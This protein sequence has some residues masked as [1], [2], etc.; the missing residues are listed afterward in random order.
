MRY[1]EAKCTEYITA[2]IEQI[3]NHLTLTAYKSIVRSTENPFIYTL[4]T[5][6]DTIES[7]DI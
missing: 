5:H 4:V 7:F 2:N 6:T 3:N 1:I